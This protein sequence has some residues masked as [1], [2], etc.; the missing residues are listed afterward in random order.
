MVLNGLAWYYFVRNRVGNIKFDSRAKAVKTKTS[1]EVRYYSIGRDT[2][3]KRILD[4]YHLRHTLGRWYLVAYCHERKDVR[5]FA[6]DQIR[7][8]KTLKKN[9]Q[10]QAGFS[11]DKFF[12]SSWRLE[13][14]GE[15]TKVVVK[16][17]KSIS[18]WF[19]KRKLHPNQQ[20]KKNK[21]GSLTLTFQVAGTG[22]IKRWI[23][24]QGSKA[25]VLEP[26]ELRKEIR[27]EARNIASI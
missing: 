13:E 11:P 8:I 4:P 26:R 12:A 3:S 24:S 7:E 18:R 10:V 6:V 9:F 1:V 14:G 19:I 25:K 22:E 27:N 23:L 20:T 16:L 17:D 21:D 15:L 5:T 2:E